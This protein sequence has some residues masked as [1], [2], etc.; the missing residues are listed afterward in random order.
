MKCF[1]ADCAGS[2][3]GVTRALDL[4]MKALE[5][6]PCPVQT[7]GPLIHNPRVVKNLEKLG[8]HC[9][10][11]LENANGGTLIIRSHGASPQQISQAKELGLCVI[12]ATCP[13]VLAAQK[14]VRNLAS[15]G[16]S[17]I[18]IGE[19][20][21]PEVEGICAQAPQAVAAVITSIEEI[22]SK[23]P[24]KI[25]IVVQT[26][27]S[28]KRVDEIVSEIKK[29]TKTL[30]F[31]NTICKATAARQQAAMSLAKKVDVMV[32]I[33]GHNSGNTRRLAELCK[34]ICPTFH[35]ESASELEAVNL[36]SY[37]SIGISAG[38]STLDSHIEE[39][40]SY[41]SKL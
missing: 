38:A 10:D 4:S 9:I 15:S 41:I 23:L 37:S 30:N 26:T 28:E 14:A 6:A 18:I 7:L 31:K 16:Y 12:D 36:D 17:L 3:Y 19:K 35:I 1:V 33:G 11:K 21:H 20:N 27:Q 2:C 25:G 24:E 22:P 13:H 32:I 39:V 34:D 5:N 29:R 40:K 8:I